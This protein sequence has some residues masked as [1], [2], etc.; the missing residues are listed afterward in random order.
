MTV[1]VSLSSDDLAFAKAGIDFPSPV[2]RAVP[3][4]ATTE[5]AK[6]SSAIQHVRLHLKKLRSN[7]NQM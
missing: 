6:E 5:L 3:V 1:T 2:T 4:K 7:T